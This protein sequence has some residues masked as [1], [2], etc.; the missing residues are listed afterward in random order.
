MVD[1]WV[2]GSK[3]RDADQLEITAEQDALVIRRP[4]AERE[5]ST[6]AVL[7]TQGTIHL[8]AKT[9]H[10]IALSEEILYGK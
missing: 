7:Q 2:R 10:E 9:V 3:L 4:R 1:Q 6:S 5:A 8:P